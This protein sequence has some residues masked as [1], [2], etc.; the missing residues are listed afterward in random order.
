MPA[1]Y[2]T[3]Q[4]QWCYRTNHDLLWNEQGNNEQQRNHDKENAQQY[5]QKQTKSDITQKTRERIYNKSAY[6]R[7]GLISKVSTGSKNTTLMSSSIKARPYGLAAHSL[8]QLPKVTGGSNGTAQTE[9]GGYSQGGK[10]WVTAKKVINLIDH[11]LSR[12]LLKPIY[13]VLV[14]GTD[15]HAAK[16]NTIKCITICW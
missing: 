9:N 6:L 8:A 4:E 15:Q 1:T 2:S 3:V 13:H 5:L 16:H 14:V 11:L 12:R 7:Q 10:G